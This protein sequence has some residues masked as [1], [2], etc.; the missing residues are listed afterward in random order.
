[1]ANPFI[2]EIKAFAGNFA[3]Q[4]W[5]LCNG[6]TLS[7]AQNPALF[8]LIGTYYGGNGTTTFALPDLRGRGVVH[9]GGSG[10]IGQ[11]GGA[12]TVT[13]TTANLPAHNHAINATNSA[14]TVANPSASVALAA[15][16]SGEPI[17]NNSTSSPVALA[18]A[19]VGSSGGGT[20]HDNRQPYLGINYI[21]ALFGV[22]PSRN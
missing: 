14:G 13:L 18:Q 16:P 15:T 19:A 20:P 9:Q 12:E 8:S 6:Q 4:N 2:G 1:M 17:Y 21:I 5:A 3:P 7:I 22:F 11:T 10:V